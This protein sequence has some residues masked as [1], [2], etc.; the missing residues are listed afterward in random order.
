LESNTKLQD[1]IYFRS[2]DSSRLY[3][4]LFVPSTLHWKDRGVSVTQATSFPYA[5]RIRLTIEGSGKFTVLIRA[6]QWASSSIDVSLN[7]QC[8]TVEA[9]PDQYITLDRAWRDGDT[10]DLRMPM[11]FRLSRLMDQPNIAAIFYGPVLLAVEEASSLS[12]WRPVTINT[13]DLSESIKGDPGQLRFRLGDLRLKPFFETFD[14][15][16]VYLNIVPE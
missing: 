15:Y 3:V 6:P 7:D 2:A 9:T 1:S 8:L 12:E 10:I 11:S 5:D 16:S 14:R 13:G 4:N